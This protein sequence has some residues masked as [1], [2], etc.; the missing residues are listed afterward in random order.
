VDIHLGELRAND[1][2]KAKNEKWL[3]EE[4]NRLFQK[5][6]G[7]RL[8]RESGHSETL[9]KISG[10]PSSMVTRYTAWSVNGFTFYTKERDNKHPVQNSG[11]TLLA[12]ALH[13]SSAKDK[14]PKKAFMNYY[15]YIEDIWELDYCGLRIAL[16]K[17]KWAD[18]N[19][20]KVDKDGVTIVD[21]RRTSYENDSFILASQATQVFYVSEPVNPDLSLV[22]HMKARNIDEDEDEDMSNIPPFTYGLPLVDEE[23]ENFDD[24]DVSHLLRSDINPIFV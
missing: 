9:S 7:K 15:G 20:V 13:V 18:N 5:W 22:V 24:D 6:L 14:N 3:Q 23:I 12:E 17:C 8:F 10:G 11:V 1:P 16:F 4:H 19:H 21:F 2:K